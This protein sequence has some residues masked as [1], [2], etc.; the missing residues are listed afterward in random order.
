[1]I[2]KNY[3]LI[4]L[5]DTGIGIDPK[6]M[7]YIW[8]CFSQVETSITRVQDGIGFGLSNSKHLVAINGGKINAESQLG[9]GSKFWFTWNIDL[10]PPKMPFNKQ[11][12]YALPSYIILKRILVIHPVESVRNAILK[13]LKMVK[14]VDA[15]DISCKGI[16][17]ARNYLEL[18]NQSAYDIVFIN[19]HEKNKEEVM[20]V[21]LKLREM[22]MYGNDLLVIFMLLSSDKGT[23]LAE[24]LTS[25]VGGRTGIIYSPI[26]WQKLNKLLLDVND[27]H[28][29]E[30]KGILKRAI[31][32]KISHA[33]STNQDLYK[34]VNEAIFKSRSRSVS[35]SKCILCVDDNFTDLKVIQQQLSELGYSTISATNSQEAINIIKSEFEPLNFNCSNLS[36]SDTNKISSRRISMILIGYNLQT[37]SVFDISRAIRSMGPHVSN[38]PIVALL[39]EELRDKCIESEINDYLTKPFKTQQLEAV[40]TKWINNDEN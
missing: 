3:L 7:R 12:N 34:D 28:I 24:N 4:E 9:K 13:Y 36:S 18:H 11:I 19:L 5:C 38:I 2:N 39:T 15:F 33:G 10:L 25:N 37:I 22:N 40:L 31:D 26:T 20:K 1:M 27:E 6:V 32:Y 35:R 8:E 16:Q 17:E 30:N 29:T 23:A 14:K 21:V